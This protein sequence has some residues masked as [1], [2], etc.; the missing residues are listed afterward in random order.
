MPAN[1]AHYL[2]AKNLAPE[3]KQFDPALDTRA[4]YYGT[5]GPDV[6]FFHRILPWMPGKSLHRCGSRLH[7]ID[8]SIT[9]QVLADYLQTNPAYPEIARSYIYG[10]ILHF[11]LDRRAHVYIN[12]AVQTIMKKEGIRYSESVIH[13]RIETN[14]DTILIHDMLHIGG[15]QFHP[16]E[17]LSDEP[18]VLKGIAGILVHLLK[19]ALHQDA[20][21]EQMVLALKDT[22]KILRLLTDE[23][24]K[25]TAVLGVAEK[26]LPHCAPAATTLI[27]KKEPDYQYDYTNSNHAPWISPDSENNVHTES[28]YDIIEQSARDALIMVKEFTSALSD[29]RPMRSITGTRNFSS[30]FPAP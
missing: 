30:G 9:F 14:L 15:N 4:L 18:D 1:A 29:G 7:K 2:F 11:C 10:F 28:F 20:T 3:L 23:S 12:A 25:K 6:L 17:N 21:P 19:H 22:S 13:N 26:L 16:W 5:Q 27:R 24:G 8:P